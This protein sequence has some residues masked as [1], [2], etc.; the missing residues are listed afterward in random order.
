MRCTAAT[1]TDFHERRSPLHLCG[2]A[3]WVERRRALLT[4]MTVWIVSM[5]SVAPLNTSR[6]TS[7]SAPTSARM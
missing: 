6:R 3:G 4:C 2:D 7:S 1:G 5:P